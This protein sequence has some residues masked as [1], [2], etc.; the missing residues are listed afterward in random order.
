MLKNGKYTPKPSFFSKYIALSLFLLLLLLISP[1]AIAGYQSNTSS[2]TT[3]NGT[4]GSIL[5]LSLSISGSTAN[6]T[7]SKKDGSFSNTNNVF[8]K[9][10]SQTGSTI[11]S[12]TINAGGSSKSLSV[13]LDGLSGFPRNFYGRVENSDGFAYVG[14]I[15]ISKT[16]DTLST[17]NLTR[18]SNGA[19][20]QSKTL[21]LDWNSVSGANIYR[22]F[23][24]KSSS[25]LNNLSDTDTFC[26]GCEVN[27]TT[28]SSSYNIRSGELNGG[29]QYFW[30]ARAGNTSGGGSKN[31][32]VWS[33]TT[34]QDTLSTPNLTSPPNGAS[35]QS[36]TPSLHWNSVSGAN[37]YRVFVAKSSST[38]NN[39]SD[40]DTFCSGCEVNDT[41]SSSS[42]NIRSGELNGGTQ[43][44]WMA[45][46]G[47][48]SGGGSKNSSVWSFT[49]SQDTLSTP[50]LTS[51]LNGAS[52]QSKTPSLQWNSVSGAN[53]YRVFVAKS[54]ST[55][56]NLSD[57]DTFCSGCEV[58]DTTPS[59]SYNIR[60][61]ELNDGTQYFW[62]IRAGNNTLG[63]GSKNSS[64]WAFTTQS[65]NLQ[66]P[67]N[68]VPVD[69][70]TNIPPSNVNFTWNYNNTDDIISTVKF[71]LKEATGYNGGTTNTVGG[72]DSR[73]IGKTTSYSSNSCGLLK[74]GQWYKWW[75]ELNFNNGSAPKGNGA[76][77]KT[78]ASAPTHSNPANFSPPDNTQELNT[79]NIPFSWDNNNQSS[80]ISTVKFSLKEASSHNGAVTSP[81]G[82]CDNKNI[83]NI[84]SYNSNSCGSLKNGQWYKWWV[85]VNFND[86]STPQGSG[87]FFKTKPAEN[88]VA[89]SIPSSFNPPDNT[90]ELNTSDVSFSWNNNNS[91]SLISNVNFS[92]KEATGHNG[93]ATNPVGDCENKSIGITSSYNSNSCGSLRNSQWHKWWIEVNFNDGSPPKG[94]GAFFKTKP[95]ENQVTH[96]IPGNFN[97][98][99]NT[100]DLDISNIGFSWDNNNQSSTISSIKFTL[101]EAASYNGA[102]TNAVGNCDKKNIGNTTSY[103][104]NSCGLLEE[105]QWY[106]WWV[107]VNFNDGS[108]PQGAGAYFMTKDNK[109]TPTPS[110]TP[111]P[112]IT[113]TPS[114]N[115]TTVSI[116]SHFE[117]QVISDT[118]IIQALPETNN[119]NSINRVEFYLDN[120]KAPQKTDFAEPYEWNWN[121]TSHSNGDHIVKTLVYD[122]QNNT[123]TDQIILIVNNE[124]SENLPE[125]IAGFDLLNVNK[126]EGNKYKGTL[127]L[128]FPGNELFHPD[129]IFTF[130]DG[131]ITDITFTTTL[132][133]N[134]AGTI[135]SIDKA[136]VSN[137]EIKVAEANISMLQIAGGLSST[138]RDITI[139]RDKISLGSAEISLPDISIGKFRIGPIQAKFK[140][141][142]D[143]SVAYIFCVEKASISLPFIGNLSTG[144]SLYKT[145]LHAFVI[146]MTSKE[147]IPI[148]ATGVRIDSIKGVAAFNFKN[149]VE[150][151]HDCLVNEVNLKGPTTCGFTG[152]GVD[153]RLELVLSLVSKLGISMDPAWTEFNSIGAVGIGGVLKIVGVDLANAFICIDTTQ[154]IRAGG[155]INIAD[156]FIASMRAQIV[157]DLNNPDDYV[158]LG[159]ASG[160]LKVPESK[161]KGKVIE[162]IIPE[163]LFGKIEMGLGYYKCKGK[164]KYGLTANTK[165]PENNIESKIAIDF[166]KP[167]KGICRGD[168]L[169]LLEGLV[170]NKT[171]GA[172]PIWSYGIK[173]KILNTVPEATIHSQIPTDSGQIIFGITWV[174]GLPDFQLTTPEKDL[175]MPGNLS[176]FKNVRYDK[177][178]Q[179]QKLYII[180]NPVPGKWTMNLKNLKGD[181][182]Y[183]TFVIG[184]NTMP[185]IEINE[186]SNHNSENN[187]ITWTANGHEDDE[188]VEISLFYDTDNSDFNGNEI[189]NGL[190]IKTT[191]GF[192]WDTTFVPAGTYYIYA[193]I[194][195]NINAPVFAYSNGT[196]E[197]SD[198]SIPSPPKGFELEPLNSKLRLT[199]QHS[200]DA[201]IAGYKTHFGTT[202]GELPVAINVGNV[203][204]YDLDNLINGTTYHVA[205]SSYDFS[206]HESNKTLTLVGIPD[207]GADIT[208]P[209]IPNGLG[210]VIL[211]NSSMLISWSA[212]TEDDIAGYKLYYD[213]D[214]SLPFTGNMANEGKSPITI[215]NKDKTSITLTGLETG[216]TYT[217]SLSSFDAL[218]NESELSEVLTV[219]SISDTDIDD[220]GMNDDW[221]NSQFGDLTTTNNKNEDFDNDGLTNIEEFDVNTDPTNEDTDGDKITDKDDSNPLLVL[222]ENRNG[223][224]DDWEAFYLVNSSKNDNDLDG[225]NNFFEFLLNLNPIDNDT[226]GNGITDGDE[227]SDGDGVAN[228]QEIIDG[229]DPSI[230][231]DLRKPLIDEAETPSPIESQTETPF[232]TE[233]ETEMETETPILEPTPA[234]TQKVATLN[235]N[236]EFARRSLTP[237]TAIVIIRDQNNNP[238][239]GVNVKAERSNRKIM[240][241]SENPVTDSSGIA[242]FSFRFPFRS[243]NG[244]ITFSAGGKSAT[245]T[246]K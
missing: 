63:I 39:L 132:E 214:G 101:K 74:D 35:N 234:E 229:T 131:I 129:I 27:D 20:N 46:A 221:E 187:I 146:K 112:V 240:V 173:S 67:N 244:V 192:T 102:T 21:T 128:N 172:S 195:D 79:S 22:V 103:N 117:R 159:T 219:K 55:L 2:T 115:S 153:L 104:S 189:V 13:N 9:L 75:V 181:E 5:R 120:D 224:P 54:S 62:M 56:N 77:F 25:T 82:N 85:E 86:G 230:N 91:A 207:A 183:T 81:V 136:S 57:T 134:L 141:V 236:P 168:N 188:E 170:Q 98:L 191:S 78:E 52:N 143:P 122:N 31:S 243:R 202:N 198:T 197:V 60:S 114:N 174:N 166:N 235:A 149:T 213:T 40:T 66:N 47:N 70:S 59:S 106:K 180:D 53:I 206:G 176:N 7:V 107:E 125:S 148:G 126:L 18:P 36:K 184:T 51:P 185:T 239:R 223:L 65:V 145:D 32:S 150:T 72:C 61:G 155:N 154:G 105:G 193:K 203:T 87:A 212:N 16:Q 64:A 201:D 164:R 110:I 49:T 186:P 237:N 80:T 133:F 238:I 144:F 160:E 15:T 100:Q 165:D 171:I 19:S 226:N 33:F 156:A 24:A 123:A 76:F 119:G 220:D 162:W 89:H 50:N 135:I 68:F 194:D 138:L 217:I 14:P 199:W 167:L 42:Y 242:E 71:S 210:I 12:G 124:P 127:L 178:V 1:N 41:T 29:T 137:N 232:A 209:A 94:S 175:I 161:W 147:G 208:P 38:L 4:W 121:T 158:I 130:I 43:Y 190:N 3:G 245:I 218:G 17:P 204:K 179:N 69:N 88:Q 8:I 92:L 37:I 231:T 241:S 111:T 83:G 222:D 73:N 23:V 90:Q 10:D 84:T 6:F 45:R 177:S 109:T 113:P 216:L 58:N 140:E 108:I 152:G 142:A 30:M 48:T 200:N 44:F 228:R 196:I 26:S 215:I 182:E 211:D 246:Q 169:E 139:T 97:P 11:K 225:L 28:S 34:S 99:D 96:S 116:I 227:D 163:S 151:T 95:A 157:K 93:S 118:V 233:T 205:I